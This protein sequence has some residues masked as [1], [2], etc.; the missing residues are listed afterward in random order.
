M[1]VETSIFFVR[2]NYI[3]DTDD[4]DFFPKYTSAY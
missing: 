2:P 4:L 3:E 1:E